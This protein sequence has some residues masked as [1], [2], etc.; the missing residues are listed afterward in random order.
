MKMYSQEPFNQMFHLGTRSKKH[1]GAFPSGLTSSRASAFR[2]S[3][4]CPIRVSHNLL[5]SE[6]NFGSPPY[7]VSLE[8]TKRRDQKWAFYVICWCALK[9]SVESSL[10]ERKFCPKCK[11]KKKKSDVFCWV[12]TF[13][14]GIEISF[15]THGGQQRKGADVNS[16]LCIAVFL[17][18]VILNHVEQTTDQVEN[19][20]LRMVLQTHKPSYYTLV[21]ASMALYFI[22]TFCSQGQCFSLL[23][24]WELSVTGMT[25]SVERKLL[26]KSSR[27]LSEERSFPSTLMERGTSGRMLTAAFRKASAGRWEERPLTEGGK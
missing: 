5:I 19:S 12:V 15:L 27:K 6:R 17:P 21:W 1:N 24:N 22:L 4:I 14:D 16:H 9:S 10:N 23:L 18:G 11:E 3:R 2:W 13:G 25:S 8:S 26:M 7:S 20:V